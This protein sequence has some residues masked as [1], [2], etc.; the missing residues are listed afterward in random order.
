MR[1]FWRDYDLT[2]SI[3]FAVVVTAVFA[4]VFSARPRLVVALLILGLFT[5]FAE[6]L[7][8]TTDR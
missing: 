6:R 5:A 3:F 4:V 8:H 7:L 1:P 2:L